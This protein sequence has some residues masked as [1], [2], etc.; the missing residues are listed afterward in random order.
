MSENTR[1]TEEWMRATVICGLNNTPTNDYETGKI[2]E[3]FK[4]AWLMILQKYPNTKLAAKVKEISDLYAANNW[5]H[6]ETIEN[7]VTKF[8]E[9]NAY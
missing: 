9:T 7:W 8:Q 3:E 6:N 1:I 5:K 4:Q 2:S